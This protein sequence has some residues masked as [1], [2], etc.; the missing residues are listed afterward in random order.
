MRYL[1]SA[2]LCLAC[3]SRLATPPTDIAAGRD[4]PPVNETNF[5]K[6][7]LREATEAEMKLFKEFWDDA[8][9][10]RSERR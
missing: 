3:C 7:E 10:R 6:L 1:I 5:V 4:A 8:P 9:K 2:L